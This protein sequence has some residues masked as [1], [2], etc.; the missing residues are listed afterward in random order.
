VKRKITQRSIKAMLICL[1]FFVKAQA[2]SGAALYFDGVDDYV[3][4]SSNLSI[5]GNDSRTVEAWIK[6][7][8]SGYRV[9]ANLGTTIYGGSGNGL[10]FSFVVNNGQLRIEIAGGGISGGVVNDGNWHFVAVTYDKSAAV[11]KYKLYID[12]K[13]SNSGDIATTINTA[14]DKL[15]IGVRD[16]QVQTN[17]LFGFFDGTIDELRIW[18][19]A[20]SPCDIQTRMNLIKV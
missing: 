19:Q 1:L 12:G 3:Q 14:S 17:G 10:R 9:I 20:L 7:T 15:R 5:T 18:N 11:N 4:S 16:D 13:L 6:T 2:Q 8:A